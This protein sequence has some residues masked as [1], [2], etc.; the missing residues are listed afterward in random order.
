MN[1]VFD[2]IVLPL[3][4]VTSSDINEEANGN[5]LSFKFDLFERKEEFFSLFLDDCT[6]LYRNAVNDEPL[7]VYCWLDELAGHIRFSAV[8]QSHEKLPFR[9]DLNNLSLEQFCE[10]LVIGCSGVYSKPGNLNIWQTYL[11]Q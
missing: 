5:M 6:D 8:S 2:G 1:K 3:K 4:I 7:T 10:S 9:G 11:Q